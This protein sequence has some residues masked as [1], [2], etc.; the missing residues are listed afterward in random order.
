MPGTNNLYKSKQ[1]FPKGGHC[2]QVGPYKI[3]YRVSGY[4]T[5]TV[6]FASGTGFPAD[7]WFKSG[8]AKKIAE[9]TTVFSLIVFLLLIVVFNLNNYLPLTAQDVVDQLHHLLKQEKIKPPYILVGHS[10]CS[11]QKCLE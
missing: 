10:L 3:Y 6:I 4:G 9:Q 11:N 7:E 2:T 8:I 5:P 1:P